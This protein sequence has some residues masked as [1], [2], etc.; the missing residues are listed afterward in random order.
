MQPKTNISRLA[1]KHRVS[2][3]T[4]TAWKSQGAPIH[5]DKK[6]LAWLASRKHIAPGVRKNNASRTKLKSTAAKTDGIAGAAQA[7]KR[8]ETAEL[9]AF[10]RMEL[11]VEAGDDAVVVADLRKAWLTISESLR[12]FDLLVEQNR[13]EAGDLIPRDKL[14]EAIRAFCNSSWLGYAALRDDLV[15]KLQGVRE[16]WEH[17]EILQ[18][19]FGGNWLTACLSIFPMDRAI[20]ETVEKVVRGNFSLSPERIEERRRSALAVLDRLPKETE[21]SQGGTK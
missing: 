21:Q 4:A 18:K 2:R 17:G 20:R 16:S 11:A 3:R 10:N 15:G 19:A 9:S 14:E 13:R 12:K 6:L 5:D 8:L 1:E 7:L